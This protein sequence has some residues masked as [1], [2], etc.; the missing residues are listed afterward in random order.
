[1]TDI[2]IA[3]TIAPRNIPL[4]QG[5]INTWI[6]YGFKV[7]AI[8]TEPEI[9]TIKPHF[10]DV[11][12]Y[13]VKPTT[14]T[15]D[16]RILIGFDEVL[17]CLKLVDTEICGIVNSDIS[18]HSKT[19]FISL[20][21]N[22]AKDAL[23]FGSRIDTDTTEDRTGIAFEKGY[24]YF[25]LNK[26]MLN[27]Y[28]PSSFHIGAP[29]WDIW[30]ALLPMLMGYNVKKLITPIAYHVKHETIWGD[31][32]NHYATHL[33]HL[34]LN[35]SKTNQANMNGNSNNQWSQL[36]QTI[37]QGALAQNELL[38]LKNNEQGQTNSKTTQHFQIFFL[39]M[40]S[41]FLPQFINQASVNISSIEPGD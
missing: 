31:E 26:D 25:F 24:D 13:Q 35:F 2:L 6:D 34:L 30:A 20:I 7:V 21:Q 41:T 11:E 3:T 29:W 18:L 15:N 22:E 17:T 36:C 9:N 32:W 14:E 12:F 33:A 27:I 23:I 4:Q 39:N 37:L 1:M 10:P 5:A 19:D 8:N 16:N 38:N 28:P 40:L